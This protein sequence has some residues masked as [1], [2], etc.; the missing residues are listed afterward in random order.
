MGAMKAEQLVAEA[1]SLPV[2]ERVE[3]AAKILASLPKA[4]TSASA[5][6]GGRRARR[7]GSAAG[8]VRM[9]DDF[10]APLEDFSGYT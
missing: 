6:G 8:R 4:E 1:L 5:A 2:E 10:D 9:A 7:A 3:V